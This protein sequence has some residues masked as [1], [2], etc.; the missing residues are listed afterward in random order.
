M[1]K[2]RILVLLEPELFGRV[3]TLSRQ[4][5][6]S[7]AEVTGECIKQS[8]EVVEKEIF[9]RPEV[10]TYIREQRKLMTQA[11]NLLRTYQTKA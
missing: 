9:T 6:V 8:L 5:G 11:D 4:T 1:A 2:K 3:E 7:M 10:Q